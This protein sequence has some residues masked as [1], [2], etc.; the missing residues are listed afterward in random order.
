MWK[1]FWML[2]ALPQPFDCSCVC[3]DGLAKTQCLS[4]ADA[5]RALPQCPSNMRCTP[6]AAG[7]LPDALHGAPLQFEDRTNDC[8]EVRVWRPERR[9]YDGVRVCDVHHGMRHNAP[10]IQDMARVTSGIRSA[11]DRTGL[12]A[13]CGACLA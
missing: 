8:R 13:G 4:V 7:D 6:R 10:G 1:L 9:Q 11:F 5:R 12:T 2:L 3:I